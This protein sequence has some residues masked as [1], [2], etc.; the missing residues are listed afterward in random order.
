MRDYVIFGDST[1]DLDRTMREKLGID[2]VAMNY[3]LEGKEYPASLD[4]ESLSARDFYNEM[5]TG[6]RITTTQ[7]PPDVVRTAFTKVLKEGKDVLYVGCS[8]AL[9]GSVNMA[10]V[11]GKELMEEFPEG[12]VRCVDALSSSFGQGIQLMWASR[13]REEGRNVNEAADYIEANRLKVHQISTVG[14]LS[15]LK[16]AGRVTATSAF[17]GNLIGVKPIIISDAR[18]QNWASKK[19][20]G[21]QAA[22]EEIARMTA[23]EIRNP[24]KQTI[25]I[26]HADSEETAAEMKKL[27][28]DRVHCKDVVYGYIG[29]IVGASVGPGTLAVYF[30]GDEITVVGEA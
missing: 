9:S 26:S 12:T 15:Y 2:Y 30:V 17:F 24:E 25:Y 21:A 28:L 16:N 19:V 18:G 11:I 8:S 1:C 27:I 22:K 23:E 20:K 13:L 5:R 10:A 3:V 29:P 7:V 4:W 14:S 6:K